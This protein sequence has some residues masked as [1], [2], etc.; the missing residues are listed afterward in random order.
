MDVLSLVIFLI[1]IIL[2][3]I[4]KINIGILAFGAAMI[5]G[6]AIG[7]S[8]KAIIGGFNSSLFVTLVGI[9]LLLK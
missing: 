1:L 2:A 9:T 7:I 8:D 5:L 4:R 3:F 6:S